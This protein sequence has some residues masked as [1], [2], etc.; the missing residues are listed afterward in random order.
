MSFLLLS[1]HRNPAHL[2]VSRGLRRHI[3]RFAAQ[4]GGATAVAAAVLFPVIVGGIG[5]GAETGYWYLTQRKLQHAADTAAHAAG[6]R[7]RA[8]D[9]RAQIEAAA[10]QVATEAGFGT[11]TL[12]VNTPPAS[13]VDA[14]KSLSVEVLLRQ[15]QPRLFSAVYDDTPVDLGARAVA[16]VTK[17][18]GV[19]CVL[20]L[21]RT[22][23]GAVTVAG[24]TSVNLDGCD[25]AS[26]SNAS[27]SFLL[28]GTASAMTAG[29]VYTVGRSSVAT[30]LTLTKCAQVKEEAPVV[31][32]PYAS[33]AEPA[34]AGTCLNKGVGTPNSTTS[35]TPT[36]NHPSGVKVMRFCGGLDV[37]GNVQFGPGLYIIEG[38]DFTVNSGNIDSS[39]IASLTGSGATFYFTNGGRL[40]LG[41]NAKLSLSAP[42][43][44]PYSGLLF[45]GSRSESGITHQINGAAG[46]TTDGAV[47]APASHMSFSGNSKTTG[48]L[49]VVARLVTFTGNSA[50]KSNCE[51][52]GTRDILTN[53]AVALVE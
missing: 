47:Y 14:G 8:G 29:C 49:Q 21:S 7:L 36:E 13:G 34:R 38:G 52:A 39:A 37:K 10:L 26:N 9:T 25:V 1:R 3:R 6:T 19:A 41:A 32:D 40:R 31:R 42:T 23:S 18:G 24:S 45:F 35:L 20:A 12:Q 30:G 28:S 11:G 22:G 51:A 15:S 46:S 27:D 4:T 43:S 16:R 17:T 2:S 33:V 53:E 50:L 44:G 5:L 48:C